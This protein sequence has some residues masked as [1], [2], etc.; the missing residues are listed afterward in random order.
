MS[1]AGMLMVV[2]GMAV[3]GLGRVLEESQLFGL[4]NYTNVDEANYTV[5]QMAREIRTMRSG[6]NGAYAFIVGNDNELSFYSDIDY[7]G[8][9]ELVRY[10]LDNG[11]LYK[12]TTKPVGF[13][14][15]YPQTSTVTK[16]LTEHVQNGTDPLFTFFNEDWPTDTAN[17]PMITPV[18]IADVGL[19]RISLTINSNED[20]G[21]KG[22]TLNTNVNL[23]MLKSNL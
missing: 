10:Y 14:A 7:D 22:Y 18:S 17:N 6:Q 16:V 11:T 2:L 5:T 21:T 19:V 4:T 1:V 12:S 20:V 3:F 9:S 8:T 15:T 23:R 13:P